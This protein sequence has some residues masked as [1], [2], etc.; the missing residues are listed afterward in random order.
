MGTCMNEF[1]VHLEE[2]AEEIEEA[3]PLRIK[4]EVIEFILRRYGLL[5]ARD[6]SRALGWKVRDVNRVLKA[7]ES[8][9]R[10]RRTK[11]GRSHVWTHIDEYLPNPM[12]Y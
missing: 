3:Q 4:R 1:P 9:G 12:Y 7:L 11:L 5:S 6:I 10:V 8:S 2:E